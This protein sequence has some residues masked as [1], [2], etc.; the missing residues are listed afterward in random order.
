MPVTRNFGTQLWNAA[1]FGEYERPSS[2]TPVSIPASAK[3]TINPLD[4]DGAVAARVRRRSGAGI[5]RFYRF[6]EAS[7]AGFTGFVWNLFCDWV[8]GTAWKPVFAGEDEPAKRGKSQ[9]VADHMLDEILSFCTPFMPFMTEEL[10]EHTGRRGRSGRACLCHAGLAHSGGL[11]DAEAA[12]RRSTG[13][14]TS[15]S[16]I[17]SG[18]ARR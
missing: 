12:V 5:E 13:W 3:L 7:A 16:G 4:S 6:N 10:W 9:A 15:S 14:W 18:G 1:R 17:R 8:S 2:A 11:E